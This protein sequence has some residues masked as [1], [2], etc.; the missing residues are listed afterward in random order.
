MARRSKKRRDRDGRSDR[1]GRKS[2][3]DREDRGGRRSRRDRDDGEDGER[4][5]LPRPSSSGMPF[6]IMGVFLF[7]GLIVIAL[8][9]SAGKSRR[10]TARKGVHRA[11]PASRTAPSTRSVPVAGSPGSARGTSRTPSPRRGGSAPA[12][13]VF[14]QAGFSREGRDNRYIKASCGQCDTA[15][16]ERVEKCP[17]CAAQVRWRKTVKCEFCCAPEK[18]KVEDADK[19]GYCAYCGGKSKDAN[20]N[21][22]VRRG[23]FGL[24]RT[25]PGSSGAP[26]SA[27]GCPVCKGSGGCKWCEKQGWLTV[28]DRFGK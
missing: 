28:P 27:G 26:G 25:R 1:G 23:L 16:E 21:P 24:D 6:I 7:V 10:V 3:K 8:A 5:R 14:V 15:L 4:Q 11:P 18:L 19:N 2:R 22:S 20:Y 9:M 12:R 17:N 13:I